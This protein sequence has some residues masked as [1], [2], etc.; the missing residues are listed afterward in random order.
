MSVTSDFID[1]LEALTRAAVPAIPAGA[2]GVSR[3]WRAP[4]DLA[5]E[6]FPHA[7]LHAPAER[8]TR[9][10]YLQIR[11]ELT[12]RIVILRSASDQATAIS[13]FNAL[14]VGLEADPTLGGVVD[15]CELVLDGIDDA[16]PESPFRAVVVTAAAVVER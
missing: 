13:D 14:R 1:A 9:F 16:G 5:T 15:F 8:V 11:L 2:L 12:E 10:P 3:E 7:I 6:N 4:T